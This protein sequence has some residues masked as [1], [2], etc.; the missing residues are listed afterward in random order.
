MAGISCWLAVS[1]YPS[2][3]ATIVTHFTAAGAPNGW[4]AKS[5]G[6][7]LYLP[8]IQAGAFLLVAGIS[9]WIAS[10]PGSL[11]FV[12][13]PGVS[14]QDLFDLSDDT[15]RRLRLLVARGLGAINLIVMV[16][17]TFV[18]YDALRVDISGHGF[19]MMIASVGVPLAILAVV[20]WL[21]GAARRIIGS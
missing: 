3:P 5:W 1:A 4:A 14:K 7:V 18:N 19:G 8:L 2:V 11:A 13:L 9:L 20:G 10:S 12:N 17:L 21:V 15:S 16:L 6:T